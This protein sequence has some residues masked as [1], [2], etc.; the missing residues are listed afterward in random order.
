MAETIRKKINKIYVD[1]VEIPKGNFAFLYDAT[2]DEDFFQDALEMEKG[3]RLNYKDAMHKGR[4]VL[5]R[6]CQIEIEKKRVRENPGTSKRLLL[7]REMDKIKYG[8]SIFKMLSEVPIKD[9][10]KD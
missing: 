6:F 3:Y 1:D 9:S 4:E 2:G 8:D 5:E 10:R 7:Q